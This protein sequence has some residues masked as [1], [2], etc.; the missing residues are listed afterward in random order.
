MDVTSSNFYKC[1]STL[2]KEKL[3]KV[4]VNKIKRVQVCIDARGRHFQQFYKCTSTL[5]KEKLQK[6]S[7]NKIKRVQVCIDAHGRHFRQLL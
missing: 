5:P 2:P 4:Y 6:V 7:V 3:Q 1:T